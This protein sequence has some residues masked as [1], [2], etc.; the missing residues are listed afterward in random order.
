VVRQSDNCVHC[1]PLTI[2]NFKYYLPLWSVHHI[3]PISVF[4]LGNP[5]LRYQAKGHSATRSGIDIL[6]FMISVVACKSFVEALDMVNMH[7]ASGI[8]AGLIAVGVMFIFF[9]CRG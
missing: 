9:Q 4:E 8:T 2:K 5:L 1:A 3:C 7:L 6:P